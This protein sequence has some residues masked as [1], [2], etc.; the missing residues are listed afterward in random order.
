MYAIVF[1]RYIAWGRK[2]MIC[3]RKI[4]ILI[5]INTCLLRGPNCRTAQ[6]IIMLP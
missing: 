4:S 5:T 1:G 3:S 2:V 6:C